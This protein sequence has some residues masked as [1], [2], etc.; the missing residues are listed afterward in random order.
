MSSDSPRAGL[1]GLAPAARLVPHGRERAL[2]PVVCGP[3]A[4]MVV[5]NILLFTALS[6][7]RR[8][9]EECHEVFDV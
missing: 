2:S 9:L 4:D 8:V 5:K 7:Q 3:L 1:V 6:A